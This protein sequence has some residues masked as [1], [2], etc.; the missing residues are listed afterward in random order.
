MDVRISAPVFPSEDPEKV[1][2]AILRIFPDA[3]LEVTE[4]DIEGTAESIDNF[5]LQIRKQKILDT[6]RKILLKGQSDDRTVFRMN[7]QVAYAGKISFT[8][9]R[10]ILGAIRVTIED[11]DLSV[12]IDKVAPNTIDGEEV[13]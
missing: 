4:R 3:V 7:K 12:L 9:E 2:E 1:K 8:E 5:K 10:T 11:S 6:A 13:K